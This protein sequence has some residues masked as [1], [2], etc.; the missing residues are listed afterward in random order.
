MHQVYVGLD[1]RTIQPRQRQ[2]FATDGSNA[3]V[4]PNLP[5]YRK[6]GTE[7]LRRGIEKRH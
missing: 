7:M 4:G 2:S 1:Q 5:D 3:P 6:K